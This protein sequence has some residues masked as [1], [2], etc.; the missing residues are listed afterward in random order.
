MIGKGR[1]EGEEKKPSRATHGC[2]RTDFFKNK[3]SYTRYFPA[4]TCDCVEYYNCNVPMQCDFIGLSSNK[5]PWTNPRTLSCERKC[6]PR[7]SPNDN[8]IVV[9]VTF[10]SI[11]T[12]HLV[13]KKGKVTGQL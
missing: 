8:I 11:V 13:T 10:S 5:I 6:I 3:Q 1:G 7:E 12:G 9:A 4:D 2:H